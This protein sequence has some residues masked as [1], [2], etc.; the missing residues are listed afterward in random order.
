[1]ASP[2]YFSDPSK[3]CSGWHVAWSSGCLRAIARYFSLVALSRSAS[4]LRILSLSACS[5]ASWKR[6]KSSWRLL[7][8]SSSTALI[9]S[10]TLFSAGLDGAGGASFLGWSAA[11]V[12]A[13]APSTRTL[14]IRNRFME[15]SLWM[16]HSALAHEKFIIAWSGRAN[17]RQAE[18]AT[19]KRGQ[20]LGT[21]RISSRILSGGVARSG[22]R[23]TTG[24][25]VARSGDRA[26]TGCHNGWGPALGTKRIN[27]RSCR[28]EWPGRETEPQRVATTGGGVARS[29]DRATT[30]EPQRVKRLAE[31]ALLWSLARC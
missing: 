1:M 14:L 27:S 29:G 20:V 26:T 16:D 10:A 5:L 7:L 6:L 9:C 3:A 24:G 23:A 12:R 2:A 4:S 13:A 18:Q 8:K 22:D 30:G 11:H 17:K 21:K 31:K 15:V 28:A 19:H 25:G